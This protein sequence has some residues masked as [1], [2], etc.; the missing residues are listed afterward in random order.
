MT[1][2]QVNRRRRLAARLEQ[3]GQPEDPPHRVVEVSE[4]EGVIDT[5]DAQRLAERG[6]SSERRYDPI[7]V[8]PRAAV[9]V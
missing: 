5:L 6:G 7:R 3:R 2:E 9:D 4:V 1:G 8:V